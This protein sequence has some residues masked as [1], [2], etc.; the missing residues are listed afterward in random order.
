MRHYTLKTFL[1]LAPN[2][3]LAQYFEQKQIPATIDFRKLKPRNVEPMASFIN[4]LPEATCHT[5]HNDFQDIYAL[6]YEGGVSMMIDAGR[7]RGMDFVP[8]FETMKGHLSK[9]FWLLLN[10]SGILLSCKILSCRDTLTRHWITRRGLP[11]QV[12]LNGYAKGN[13]LADRLGTFFR[14]KEG[15]GHSCI[16]DYYDH[17]RLQFFFAYPEGYSQTLLHYRNGGLKRDNFNPAFEVIFVY[18]VING[19]LDTYY[20]GNR[21]TVPC[22]Q[23]IFV[24]TMF[25]MNELPID[26]APSFYLEGLKDRKFRFEIAHDSAIRTVT[27]RKMTIS[28]VEENK[29]QRVDLYTGSDDTPDAIYA[30]LDKFFPEYPADKRPALSAAFPVRVDIQVKFAVDADTGRQP[31]LSFY[32][33]QSDSTDL[34]YE[35]RHLE[36]RNMLYASGVLLNDPR[37]RSAVKHASIQPA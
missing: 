8:I 1:R 6:A 10:H 20:E 4:S 5:I 27:I 17:D 15:R 12:I 36:V 26:R 24:S 21:K 35:G 14:E 2:E 33:T 37:G 23:Q 16:V 18:D 25:G 22:L 7:R 19:T 28:F 34:D 29:V 32:L 13:A 30:M 11:E 31:S 3:M 9:A